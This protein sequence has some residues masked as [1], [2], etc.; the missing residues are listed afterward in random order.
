MPDMFAALVA[1]VDEHQ[2]CGELDGGRNNGCVRLACSYG[3][4]IVQP[5]S[6]PSKAPA[7]GSTRNWLARLARREGGKAVPRVED[8]DAAAL[9]TVVRDVAI[10]RPSTMPDDLLATLDVVGGLRCSAPPLSA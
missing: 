10:A 7:K 2:G 4:Q 5:V 9:E 1:F 8:E 6:E 3:A